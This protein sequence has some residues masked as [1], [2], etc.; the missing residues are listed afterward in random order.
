M[1]DLDPTTTL[2]S[3]DGI[4]AFDLISR[5]AMLQGLMEVDG[6]DSALPFVR[7]FYSTPSMYWWTDDL[8]VTHEI[9]QGASCLRCACG[10]HRALVHMSEDLLDS[11][12]LFAFM[13]D[14]YVSSARIEQKHSTSLWTARCGTTHGSV[15]IKARRSVEQRWSGSRGILG[16]DDPEEVDLLKKEK[17]QMQARTSPETQIPQATQF[18]ERAKKRMVG[19]DETIR[20]AAE[21]LRQAESEKAAD[22]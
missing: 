11:E 9:W 7:Q 12:R 15:S 19:A 3:V 20:Q 5:E 18:L 13:D 21:A 1:T 8:G 16:D 2:L 14:I 4:G 6:G 17:A 10:Q 22:I